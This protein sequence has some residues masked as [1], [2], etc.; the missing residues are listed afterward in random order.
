[1]SRDFAAPGLNNS[2]ATVCESAVLTRSQI[3]L[4]SALLVV[5]APLQFRLQNRLRIGVKHLVMR[6]YYSTNMSVFGMLTI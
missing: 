1:M 4:V 5:V 3:N 6:S 2:P